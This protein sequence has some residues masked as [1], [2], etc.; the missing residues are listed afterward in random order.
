MSVNGGGGDNPKNDRLSFPVGTCTPNENKAIIYSSLFFGGVDY[1]Y[2]YTTPLP[3]ALIKG[4]QRRGYRGYN[5][6]K[7]RPSV[8]KLICQPLPLPLPWL[9]YS[10]YYQYIE[11]IYTISRKCIASNFSYIANIRSN[12]RMLKILIFLMQFFL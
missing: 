8:V 12:R 4:L 11:I 6:L 7:A 10:F 1:K 2:S 3:P 9:Y 5:G